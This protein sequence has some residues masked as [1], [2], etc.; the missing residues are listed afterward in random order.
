MR[1]KLIPRVAY[2]IYFFNVGTQQLHIHDG[3]SAIVMARN[4]V[5]ALKLWYSILEGE[6]SIRKSFVYAAIKFKHD[7]ETTEGNVNSGLL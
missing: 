6:D 2:H 7:T 4:P 5:Q 3:Y 1:V